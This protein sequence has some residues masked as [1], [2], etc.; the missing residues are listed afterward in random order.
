M[1]HRF[2]ALPVRGAFDGV[3][4]SSLSVR[5]WPSAAEKAEWRKAAKQAD[6]FD[7]PKPERV[8]LHPLGSRRF[9]VERFYFWANRSSKR[10]WPGV[11]SEAANIDGFKSK[12]VAAS[13]VSTST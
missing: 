13:G 7:L 1:I 8:P 2:L 4:C 3:A 9:P 11:V 5:V 10:S 6:L 12:P